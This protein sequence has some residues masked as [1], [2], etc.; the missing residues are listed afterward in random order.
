MTNFWA[1]LVKL[2]CP[3]SFI[4]ALVFRDAL[5]D[6]NAEGCI[7]SAYELS[8]SDRNLASFGPVTQVFTRLYCVQLA[9][10]STQVSVITSHWAALPGWAG[11]VLGYASHTVL[12]YRANV[13]V[14]KLTLLTHSNILMYSNVESKQ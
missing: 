10:T 5:E 14:V 9:S 3:R 1:E 11:Y 12:V 13:V 7:N 6:R 4:A 8:T 2:A